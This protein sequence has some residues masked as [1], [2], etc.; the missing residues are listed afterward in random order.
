[1]SAEQYFR[2]QLD[3]NLLKTF[4]EIVAAGGISR[5]S[6]E[7]SRKQPAI[8]LALRR[9]EERLGV[10][11]C[12]RGPRGFTLTAEGEAAAEICDEIGQL[13]SLL[14]ER[15][16]ATGEELRGRVRIRL[17][18]SVQTPALDQALER[19][20]RRYP[21]V[22]IELGIGPWKGSRKTCSTASSMPASAP[23]GSSTPASS[24]T[25]CSARYSGSTCGPTH[26]LF[27]KTVTDLSRLVNERFVVKGP[28]E[29]DEIM[30]F[31]LRHGLGRNAV[32]V[33]RPH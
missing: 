28:G 24:T 30:R 6:H 9:L 8:S 13:V 1:M 2:R 21:S 12:E 25:C 33:R 5:A 11:L 20:H 31:R 15:V 22:E 32:G 4:Q 23:C 19:F 10:R 17:I 16:A 18:S 29:P 27:G 3:W 26:P 14:P 7:L